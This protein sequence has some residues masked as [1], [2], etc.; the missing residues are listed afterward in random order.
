LDVAYFHTFVLL[1]QGTSKHG[2][3]LD[4]LDSTG[5]IIKRYSF[6]SEVEYFLMAVD[7]KVIIPLVS[8]NEIA[9]FDLRTKEVRKFQFTFLKKPQ[10]ELK[11]YTFNHTRMVCFVESCIEHIREKDHAFDRSNV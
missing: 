10:S 5:T 1:L 4:H 2:K 7:D 3:Y 6:D 11:V 8:L 9:V